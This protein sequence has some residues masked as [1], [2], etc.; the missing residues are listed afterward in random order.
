MSLSVRTS[1]YQINFKDDALSDWA[2]DGLARDRRPQRLELRSV[3]RTVSGK[4]HLTF[5]I[6]DEQLFVTTVE[7]AENDLT[8]KVYPVADLVLPIPQGGAWAA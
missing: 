8:V 2:L 6:K 1:R 3:L 5:V 4:M 7:D